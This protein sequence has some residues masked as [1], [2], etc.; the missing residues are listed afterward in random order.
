MPSAQVGWPAALPE[1]P[2]GVSFEAALGDSAPLDG[3][4]LDGWAELDGWA[5]FEGW[6]VL[7]GSAV[8]SPFRSPGADP[9]DRS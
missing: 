9:A 3:A 8:A 1:S 5:A 7:E 4:V 6:A 2:G